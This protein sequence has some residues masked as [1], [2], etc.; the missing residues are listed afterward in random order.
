[1]CEKCWK[2]YKDVTKT[3]T[4]HK[5]NNPRCNNTYLVSSDDKQQTT[6]YFFQHFSHKKHAFK[7]A[8][9]VMGY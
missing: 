7:Y 2:K 8:E 5:G 6:L 3:T 9:I 4:M 1:L